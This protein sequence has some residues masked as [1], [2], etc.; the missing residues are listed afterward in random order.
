[1]I[2]PVNQ[3]FDLIAW[4]GRR[5]AWPAIYVQVIIGHLGGVPKR[6][7]LNQPFGMT[8][9]GPLWPVPSQGP[10][11]HLAGLRRP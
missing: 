8:S 9:G 1:M 2:H 7:S 4:S 11:M 3:A 10:R 5:L 6:D